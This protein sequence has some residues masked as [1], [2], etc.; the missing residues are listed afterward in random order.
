MIYPDCQVVNPDTQRFCGECGISLTSFPEIPASVTKTLETPIQGLAEEY[1]FAGIYLITEELGRG[2]LG[3]FYK[4][5]DKKLKRVMALKFLPAKLTHI[6]DIKDRFIHEAQ[7][8]G[9]WI[10]SISEQLIKSQK[11]QISP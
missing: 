6:P 8:A 2:G 4:D 7:T 10:A 1:M 11:L 5:E 9:P 3:I